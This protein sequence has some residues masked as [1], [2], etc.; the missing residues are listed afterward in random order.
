MGVWAMLTALLNLAATGGHGLGDDPAGFEAVGSV[1]ARLDTLA[2]PDKLVPALE[3]MSVVWALIFLVT[4]LVAMVNGFKLYK[5]VTITLALAIGVFTGYF[6][7]KAIN[8][9]YVVA[10]C[11]GLLLAVCCWPLMKYAVA[12]IGGLVGAFLGA[13]LWAATAILASDAALKQN[14]L[15]TYWVGGLVGLVFCG[16]LAFLLF[17]VTVVL[18]TSVTGETLAMLG[19][20]ALLVR[21]G[22][23]REAVAQWMTPNHVNT[24]VLPL[25][26]FVPAVIGLVLQHTDGQ[27]QHKEP[28]GVG[29]SAKSSGKAA[30]K[31]A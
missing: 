30:A 9:E 17:K 31:A 15:A 12:V 14:I 24:I 6:L 11:F 1:F 25:L 21:I 2:H 10:G 16:M 19:V 20:L 28:A 8:A 27:P 13:N 26:A 29:A 7:G 3:K 22:G 5:W 18:F 23:V 4:G